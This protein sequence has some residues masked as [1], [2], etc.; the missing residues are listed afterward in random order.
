MLSVCSIRILIFSV[1]ALVSTGKF[2]VLSKPILSLVNTTYVQEF[3]YLKDVK[4]N[5]VWISDKK[6]KDDLIHSSLIFFEIS[7]S[8]YIIS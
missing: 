1:F 7:V 3:G 8:L 2:A 5:S 6:S 4:W